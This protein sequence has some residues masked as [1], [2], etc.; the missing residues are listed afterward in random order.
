MINP[1]VEPENE[2]LSVP[3]P[4]SPPFEGELPSPANDNISALGLQSYIERVRK[5]AGSLYIPAGAKAWW[6]P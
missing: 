3:K 2:P 6:A 4:I 5:H 1:A